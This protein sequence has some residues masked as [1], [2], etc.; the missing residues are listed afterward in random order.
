MLDL[1]KP[2]PGSFFRT[3]SGEVVE[4]IGRS[5]IGSLV[6]LGPTLGLFA[7]GQTGIH[8]SRPECQIAGLCSLP[9]ECRD[10]AAWEGH[11]EAVKPTQG[12]GDAEAGQNLSTSKYDG[13]CL[14]ARNTQQCRYETGE[15]GRLWVRV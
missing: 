14:K 1:S 12:R 10:A 13:W 11:G 6:F 5:H 7:T 8:I 15:G 3:L 4:Y 2:M 9:P